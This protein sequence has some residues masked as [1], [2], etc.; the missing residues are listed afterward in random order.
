MDNKLKIELAKYIFFMFLI[1]FVVF[2]TIIHKIKII[3]YCYLS[4]IINIYL[5]K[6]IVK[7]QTF[8]SI[9]TDK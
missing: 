5:D 2:L 8:L 6:T 9:I 1:A 3:F 4:L 7:L